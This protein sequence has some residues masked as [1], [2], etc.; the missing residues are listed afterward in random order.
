MPLRDM[1]IAD[2]VAAH[3]DASNKLRNALRSGAE[4]GRLPCV[5]IGEYLDL[6]AGA[7]A[8]FMQRVWSFGRRSARELEA[9]VRK[10]VDGEACGGAELQTPEV[11]AAEF[12][13]TRAEDASA[14]DPALGKITLAEVTEGALLSTRLT[15]VLRQSEVAG[16]ELAEF[17]ARGGTGRA[18]LQRVPNCGRKTVHELDRHCRQFA[19]RMLAAT[20]TNQDG[21]YGRELLSHIAVSDGP[22]ELLDQND[23]PGAEGSD[24]ESLLRWGLAK[25]KE[26]EVEVLTSR[27]GLDGRAPET[28]EDVGCRM[29]VTRERIRQIEANALRKLQRLLLAK[30]KPALDD[31]AAA[32]WD[33]YDGD[34]IP[35]AGGTD[36]RRQLLPFVRLA[37][38][39]TATQ[40]GEWIRAHA[41]AATFGV[42][43][44]GADIERLSGLADRLRQAAASNLLPAALANLATDADQ[45]TLDLAARAETRLFV[46]EGY[47]FERRPHARMKRAVRAH[48]ILAAAGRSMSLQELGNLYYGR[49]PTDPCS[50]RDLVIVMEALPHLFIEIEE[51]RWAPL[52]KGAAPADPPKEIKSRTAEPE[53]DSAT[54]AGA[55]RDALLERG[56]TSLGDLYR[57]G[58]NIVPPGRSRISIGPILLGRPELFL[59]ILPGVYALHSQ[60]PQPAEVASEPLSFLLNPYQARAYAFARRAGEPWEA[61]P[62]WTAEAE[63]RLCRWARFEAEPALFHSLLAIAEI[64]HWPVSD[65]IKAEWRRLAEHRARFE[66]APPRS[67]RPEV[68][69]PLD[70]LLAALIATHERGSANWVLFNRILARRIDSVGGRSLLAL[71]LGLGALRAPET[72]RDDERWQLPHPATEEAARLADELSSTMSLSGTLSWD[73]PLGQTIADRALTAEESRLGW[74]TIEGLDLLLGTEA[75]P[76]SAD[77][78][79]EDEDDDALLERLMQEHRRAH[80][81][82][83]RETIAQ[84]LLE[85]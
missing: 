53:V 7:S 1:L 20:G 42:L 83:K 62:L 76:E 28:L 73:S 54:L 9:L 77:A 44:P 85:E 69:P 59:R 15:N 39:V 5:T 41:V 8:L 23:P 55:I 38:D 79:D 60:V 82:Q 84:W 3:P 34:F 24:V 33:Q 70:R 50:L 45:V 11:E 13:E 46:A 66:L 72:E 75:V 30:L 36:F 80:E 37:L 21:D 22:G 32:F 17:L 51:G 6:G 68:R 81:E 26:R 14:M 31:A 27:Y 57:D 61:F 52:G 10:A 19:L 67:A 2:F 56:P 40:A 71:M 25:L 16:M 35:V 18:F 29:A 65:D 78:F 58:D 43:R 64:E 47:L 49:A 63:Y 48:A 74:A 12:V 4:A